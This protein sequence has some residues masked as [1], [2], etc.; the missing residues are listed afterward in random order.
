MQLKGIIFDWA[1]TV[2]DFGLRCPIQAFQTA[3]ESRGLKLGVEEINQFMGIHK[4]DHL[5]AILALPEVLAHWLTRHGR[6]PNAADVAD[7]Y[8]RVEEQMLATVAESASLT[9]GV[10][11]AVDL[12]RT[13][14]LRI[15][16]TTGYTSVMM[17]R[18]VP[19]AAAKGYA[20]DYWIAS[21][22]VPQGRP[23]PWMIFKNMEHLQ[24]C[25]PAALLKVGDTVADIGEANQAGLWSVAVVES[26]SLVGRS[27][28]ELAAMS[29][30]ERHRVLHRATKKLAEAGAHFVIKN[31]AELGATIEQI[32]HRLANGQMPPRLVA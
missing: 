18:L 9:P 12:A 24:I 10:T 1:G 6:P 7:L 31:L 30:K 16:S 3:F 29:E 27:V 32:E 11:E 26:S 17:R 8:H 19:A 25:P 20:P 21:D 28:A 5:N 23:W 13:R 2:V 22:Q 15:G 4:R 14:G